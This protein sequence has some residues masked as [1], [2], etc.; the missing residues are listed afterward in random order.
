MGAVEHGLCGCVGDGGVDD[1]AIGRLAEVR[2]RIGGLE[3]GLA[4]LQMLNL[5]SCVLCANETAVE[6]ADF[7]TLGPT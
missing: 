5:A 4:F 2:G 1:G 6:A 3:I 7:I